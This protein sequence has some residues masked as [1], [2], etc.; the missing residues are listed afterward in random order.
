MVYQGWPHKSSLFLVPVCRFE[1]E[2]TV[3]SLGC[4]KEGSGSG[5]GRECHVLP[6]LAG[7]LSGCCSSLSTVVCARLGLCAAAC[8][9][10]S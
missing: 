3:L 1:E 5:L 6:G 2:A 10:P 9:I 4:G 7:P 8:G